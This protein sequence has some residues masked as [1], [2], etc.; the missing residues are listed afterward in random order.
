MD[1]RAVFGQVVT[2]ALAVLLAGGLAACGASSDNTGPGRSPAP[3]ASV[4]PSAPGAGGSPT[5]PSGPIQTLPS[6]KPP[7]KLTPPTGELTLTG[8]VQAG[9]E[10]GCL[11]MK[12]GGRSYQ[13]MD[14]DPKIV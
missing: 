11:L 7:A 9:V 14:G 12:A 10:P 3:G 1:H 13:L 5:L 2:T 8:T 6:Q 4:A